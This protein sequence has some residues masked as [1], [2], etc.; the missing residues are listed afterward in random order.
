MNY[1]KKFSLSDITKHQNFN[2]F[3]SETVD[4]MISG[5]YISDILEILHRYQ[6]N[7]SLLMREI[8]LKKLWKWFNGEIFMSIKMVL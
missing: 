5:K 7:F 2:D 6:L 4:T 1:D 8:A 3:T